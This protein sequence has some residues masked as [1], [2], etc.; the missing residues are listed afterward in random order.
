MYSA[1]GSSTKTGRASGRSQA[2]TLSIVSDAIAVHP[3]VG[4]DDPVHLAPAACGAALYL[5]GLVLTRTAMSRGDE[6]RAAASA[7]RVKAVVRGGAS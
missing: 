7:V 2:R 5:A 1:R 4:Y 3:A 6:D